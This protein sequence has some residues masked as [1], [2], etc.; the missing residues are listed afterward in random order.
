MIQA[1]G[2]SEE[3]FRGDRFRDHPQALQGNGDILCLTQPDAVRE[4]HSAY[5]AA[6]ADIIET[7]SFT[8]NATAQAD[9]GLEDLV[10]EINNASAQIARSAVSSFD[11]Q[12]KPRFVAG[13][14]GPTTK[15]A[16][17]ATRVEDPSYRAIR[18]E[19]LVEDYS[20]AVKGLLDGGIDLLMVETIYDTLNAKAA[21]FAIA[22]TFDE[23]RQSVPLMISG[24]ITDA[25]GRLLTGQT[26]EAFWTSIQHASPLITGLNC[27]L[28]AEALRPYTRRLSDCASTFVSCHPNA[29]LPNQFG[30]YNESVDTMTK[31]IEA[32]VDEGIVNMVG[33]CCGT[34]PEFTAA[35]HEI[36]QGKATRKVPR[37]QPGLH[38]AGME[39]LTV[40]D[41][42]LFVNVGERTNITGSARF[43]RLITSGDYQ[44]ALSVAKQQVDNGAQ[45]IDINMDEALLDGQAAMRTFVDQL[46]VDP[47]IARVPLMIDSSDWQVIEAGLQC[48]PGRCVVNSISLKDGEEEFLHRANLCR[49]YGA[50]V[51]VMAFDE[52]GQADT[53]ERKIEII[54]RSY[55]LLT[56]EINFPENDIIFDANILTIATGIEAHRDYGKAYLQTCEWITDN[57]P[58]TH[59]SGGVSNISFSFRGNDLVREAIHTVFLYHAIKA[60][61]TMGIVNAGQLG[62]YEALPEDLRAGAESAVL[63][64]DPDAGQHL[65]ELAQKYQ[66]VDSAPREV[67]DEEWRSFEVDKRL[68][69]ALVNGIADYIVEDTEESRSNLA[70]PMDVIEGPL[71]DGM[72]EVGDLFGAGKMFLPQVVQSAQVM[73]HAVDYLEPYL[74]AEKAKTGIDHERG[75]I[76][77]ATVNGDVHDIGKN[78]VGIVLQCNNYRVIDLGVMVPQE[79]IL[80][81]AE[82]EGADIVGLSGLITPSLGEMVKVAEEMQRRELTTPLLIGGATTSKAHTAVRIDPAYAGPVVYVPDASRTIGVVSNLLSE[83]EI[84]SYMD[85]ISNE[86]EEIRSRH[87]GSKRVQ[88]TLTQA[89]ENAPK[90]DWS[91]YQPPVPTMGI[92]QW[93]I[94]VNPEELRNYIDWGPFFSA[95][96]YR[97][98]YPDVL[99][100]EETRE[101]ARQLFDK[102]NTLLDSIDS[103]DAV[104]LLGA[105]GFSPA[106][107][108]GDDIV[109]YSDDTR[110]HEYCVNYNLRQQHHQDSPNL[111]LADWIAPSGI[112]D[113]IGAFVVSAHDV[114]SAR[115]QARC[116]DYTNLLFKSLCDRLVEAFAEFLHEKVRQE[117]WGY[118]R[119][120]K[121]SNEELISEKYQGIR[122]APGYPSCPDHVAKQQIFDLLG[123]EQRTRCSLTQNFAIS[124]ASAVAGWYFSHPN[125]RYYAVHRVNDDQLQD[126]ARRQGKEIDEVEPWL[127]FIGL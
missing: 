5:I 101:S 55:D 120:E 48:V 57:L 6:G 106:N 104:E 122:P 20:V 98:K 114:R 3:D 37:G 49:R 56:K 51:I 45:V 78:I 118:S 50:A 21:I 23:K 46:V 65:L 86:Y 72:N 69:Y 91:A 34:T 76:V 75:T 99:S 84:D 63:N 105:Y 31:V 70:S 28:G 88:R 64:T 96:S 33:G 43:K 126:F 102:A 87:N 79:R 97:V 35:F 40:D 90:L 82:R 115:E 60:G 19:N 42:S 8:A 124:P 58:R 9:Y 16:S 39:H 22:K 73:R 112:A 110:Q 14:L 121:F 85:S 38:L 125:A 77:L 29:G 32:I 10:Y 18:F 25:S 89:R 127:S 12:S 36:I 2:F 7:N 100:R 71:M 52:Q 83:S 13:V 107:S 119:R 67:R 95:W 15:S 93:S 61:M 26:V 4:I 11:D 113:Y 92:G 81:T 41:D 108:R 94:Q 24:T 103:Q 59:T 66:S 1:Y 17:L 27:A 116:D 30:E 74:L 109:L 68:A 62:R 54:Q 123:A 111:C 80:D 47:T 53:F 44:A 117:Y